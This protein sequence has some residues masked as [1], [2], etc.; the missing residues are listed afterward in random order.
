MTN[1]LLSLK[2]IQN[3][4][5]SILKKFHEYCERE[6]LKYSLAYGTMIGVVRHQGFIP[7]D[8]DIDVMMPRDD[9]EKLLSAF[10]NSTP[11]DGC[12]LLCAD[13]RKEYFYPFAKICDASTVARMED[14]H[15]EHGIWMDVFPVDHIPDNYS[16]A[17]KLHKKIRFQKNMIIA[18]TT[19][20]QTRN[21]N[22]KIVPKYLYAAMA[23]FIGI[24]KIVKCIEVE[25]I[26]YNDKN[27]NSLSVLTWQS[28]LAGKMSVEDFSSLEKM[29]FCNEEFYV[30]KNYD[31]Y[32]RGIYG[33]YMKMPPENKRAIHHLSAYYK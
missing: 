19:N 33:D 24:E 20:F 4:E 18:Y 23:R 6:N 5:F 13:N 21:R 14:N 8:D 30:I 29:S 22:W 27:T 12:E 25:A 11:I 9:Y 28:S 16:A 26:K 10:K 32:L 2:E 1:R 15:T 7:W 3:I 31:T 17:I